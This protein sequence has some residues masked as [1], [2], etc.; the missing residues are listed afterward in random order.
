[1]PDRIKVL[2]KYLL[3]IDFFVNIILIFQNESEEM[4]LGSPLQDSLN[5]D[6]SSMAMLND[7]FMEPLLDSLPSSQF[8]H[9]FSF[10]FSD[11]HYR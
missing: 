2:M 8:D 7:S 1:M 6:A 5:N 4:S 10:E 9:E 11:Q 3:N